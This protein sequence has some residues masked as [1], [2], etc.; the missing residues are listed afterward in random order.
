MAQLFPTYENIKRLKVK[1]TNGEL[2]LLNFL[3]ENLNDKVQIYFRP[4]INGDRPDV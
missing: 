4:F 2:Y 1:P 3:T